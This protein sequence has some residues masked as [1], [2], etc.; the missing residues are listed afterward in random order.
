MIARVLYE[1]A[2]GDI[3]RLVRDPQSGVP[4]VEHEPNRSSGGRTSLTEVGQFL[5]TGGGGPEHQALLQLI[6]TLLDD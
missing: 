2:N 3:W 4:M 5:R 1:S 6:G